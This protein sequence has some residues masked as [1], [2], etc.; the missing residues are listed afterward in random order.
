[1]ADTSWLPRL[2]ALRSDR[3]ALN[4]PQ[5]SG[6]N[7]N[8]DMQQSDLAVLVNLLAGCSVCLN[9]GS[10]LSIDALSHGKPVIVT[11]FDAD[12]DLPWWKSARRIQR[13][14][15]YARL[16]QT[17]GV[18]PVF[19][20]DELRDWLQTFL[21]APETNLASRNEALKLECGESDGKASVR[22]A[23]ALCQITDSQIQPQK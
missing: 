7:L 17:G 22:V 9:S 19:S 5:L 6:G 8:W 12:R 4:M 1:M 14:P 3:V 18:Q 2:Q 11:F 20:F 10:T 15:H 16:L 21:A 13:F 23:E